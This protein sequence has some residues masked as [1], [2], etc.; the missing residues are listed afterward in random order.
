HPDLVGKIAAA[1]DLTPE[2]ASEQG[3]AGLDRLTSDER[4]RFTALNEA[5]KARFGIPFIL[6]V[7]GLS[8]ADI[9]AAFE[10]R[11]TSTPERE[12]ATAL[13]EVEKIALIRLKEMLPTG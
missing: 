3:S 13:A 9:L 2:S 11:L 12:F 7:K 5:Y 8:K 1:G 4:A 10:Q 6:A